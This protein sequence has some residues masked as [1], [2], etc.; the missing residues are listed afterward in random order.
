MF[1]AW[2]IGFFS[3]TAFA[4]PS[5][6]IVGQNY[7]LRSDA[8]GNPASVS[9]AP[10]ESWG[11]D[12]AGCRMWIQEEGGGLR[13]FDKAGSVTQS[14]EKVARIL[15]GTGEG[16]FL[17]RSWESAERL[18]IRDADG[19]RLRVFDAD[20]VAQSEQVGWEDRSLG[21][22]S[23]NVDERARKMSIIRLD[24]DFAS[25]EMRT[26]AQPFNTFGYRRLLLDPARKFLWI[27]YTAAPINF[28]YAPAVQRH[29]IAVGPPSLWRSDEKGLSF[30]G[31]LDADGSLL[32]ARDIPSDSGFTVPFYSY[33]Q[34][35]SPEGVVSTLYQSD[36]NFFIDSLTVDATSIYMVQRSIF[37]SDGSFIVRWDREPGQIG[38]SLFRLPGPARKIFACH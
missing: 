36:I 33:I 14:T 4:E 35:H 19:K 30:D 29:T 10:V 22:W 18:E 31:I 21:V 9:T 37:G 17:S 26:V 16:S 23:L 25:A 20:W 1:R 12:S 15:S 38:K 8:S 7:V 24:S 5:L 11:F 32:L 28:P 2:V 34:R 27:A 6:W 13:R 3:W